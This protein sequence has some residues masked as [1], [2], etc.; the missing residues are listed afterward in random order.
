MT[1]WGVS[2][3]SGGSFFSVAT[4]VIEGVVLGGREGG[5]K[6]VFSR[7]LFVQ[8]YTLRVRDRKN[9]ASPIAQHL[10]ANGRGQWASG[11]GLALGNY[12]LGATKLEGDNC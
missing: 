2:F 3:F 10:V 7:G 6:L 12:K 1:L 11:F 9:N 8:Y 5:V 4:R